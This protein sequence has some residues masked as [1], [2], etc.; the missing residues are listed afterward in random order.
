M[1]ILS[2]RTPATR[3][4]M[5]NENRNMFTSGNINIQHLNDGNESKL[6]ED[7]GMTVTKELFLC[8][9]CYNY[10]QIE[11]FVNAFLHAIQVY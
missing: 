10:D 1:T 8:R 11:R 5:V 2:T 3:T 6:I 4:E 7:S 9:I